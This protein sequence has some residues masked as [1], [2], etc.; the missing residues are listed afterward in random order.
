MSIYWII[1]TTDRKRRK[2][3]T[4][5]WRCRTSSV[6]IAKAAAIH[7]HEAKFKTGDVMAITFR[8]IGQEETD[9]DQAE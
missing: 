1:E 4:G 5:T 2:P 3:R 9:D 7:Y 6:E 8:V